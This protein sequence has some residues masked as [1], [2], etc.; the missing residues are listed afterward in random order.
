MKHP[1]CY[2]L[3]FFLPLVFFATAV[4]ADIP[5][6]MYVINEAA[7]TISKMNLENNAI[8]SNI[9]KTG[10]IPNQ[11]AVHNNMIYIVNSGTDDILVVD[12]ADDAQVK[13]TIALPSGSNPWAIGFVGTNK[14]YVTN[15]ISNTVAVIDL[16]SAIVVKEIEVGKA[17]QGILIFGNKA[18]VANTGYAGWG[19][20]YEQ[21]TVSIIDVLTDSVTH[22]VYVPTNVQDL[23]VDPMGRIHAV[24]TGDYATM[25]GKVAIIDLYTGPFWDT[26]AV[27][28]TIA[29]GW[30]SQGATTFQPGDL[31]ITSGGKGYCVA[32]GDGVNGFLCSYDAFADT[33]LRDA[34]DPILI[35]PNVS[36]LLYD[37]KEN[38]LWIPY[39]TVW[40]GDGFVQKFDVMEDSVVWISDVL[41]N[42]TKSLTILEPIFDSDPYADAVVSFN[43]GAGAGFGQN[44]FPDNV[45]G[46]PDPDP[47]ISEYNP[48]SKPQELLSL[49]HGGEIVLEF[50][51]NYIKDGEGVDFTVFE[52]VFLVFGTNEPF[53]E[54]AH[55]SVSMDGENWV[56]FPGDTATWEGFAGVTPT[57]DNQN[58]TDPNVSGGDSFDLA[59]VGLPYARFVKLTDIGDLKQ[60]GD[61][62]DFFDLDAVVAVN[63]EPGQPT[64]VADFVTSNPTDF[65]LLQNYPNPFNPET[66][67][68]FFVDKMKPVELKIFNSLGQEVKM[69]VNEVKNQGQY[70]VQWDGKDASG[71]LV[72]SGIYFYQ[73]KSGHQIQIRK[74]TL[75]R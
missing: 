23:A 25:S 68:R 74:M 6:S 2:S 61:W 43:P 50:T 62:N 8:Q 26:P 42:G 44:Y 3:L 57:R 20:P 36:H 55:V 52:N 51:D 5:R 65:R 72:G 1:K 27:V 16:E 56:T 14:A 22:A 38:A 4:Q 34:S 41:G 59:D 37:Q 10:Q 69:L 70:Q 75:L 13:Q 73:L 7:E 63:S 71:K 35:G 64:A 60:E 33:V 17:P 54:A 39:M 45:L 9:L 53:I 67:I 47:N 32:W 15:W 66:T 31:A 48:S 49:G 40:G 24:C 12:P 11:I 46:A 19:L 28:D 58:P 18:F 30:I 29:F 21:A